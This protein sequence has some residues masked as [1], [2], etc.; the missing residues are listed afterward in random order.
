[1]KHVVV[2][3]LMVVL[4]AATSCQRPVPHHV[5]V[6]IDNSA[7]LFDSG[8][9]KQLS[10][11][12]AC[13]LTRDWADTA[14]P[15]SVFAISL[16]LPPDSLRETAVLFREEMPPL[17][18]PERVSRKAFQD[19]LVR[20]L[21]DFLEKQRFDLETSPIV[22]GSFDL[23]VLGSGLP[24][25]YEMAI[26]GTDGLQT[27]DNLTLST[28]YLAANTDDQ[29]RTKAEKRFHRP[30]KQPTRLVMYYAPGVVGGASATGTP[31]SRPVS[32]LLSIFTGAWGCPAVEQRSL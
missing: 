25:T 15:G 3:T 5:M 31:E 6:L 12:Q 10:I 8:Q 11:A 19:A 4:L 16:F 30:A 9:R 14:A 20:R 13:T 27:S 2:A 18:V 21:S 23:Q 22:E 32:I 29:I 7:S 1:M 28:A 26:I 17:R 24:G